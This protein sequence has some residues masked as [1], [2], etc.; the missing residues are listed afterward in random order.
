MHE[1]NSDP[2]ALVASHQMT[3]SPYQSHQ[4]SYQNSQHQQSVSPYQSLQYG[5]PFESQQYSVN[6]SSTPHLITY[7][8]NN[9]QTSVHHNVYSPPVSIPQ[10]EYSPTVNQQSE[11]SQLDS[12]LT[13]PV[14][15]RGDDLI[16]AI[17]HVM[18]L[19]SAV[20]TSRFPTTNNQL[21]NSSNPRQ[22]A[23]INNGRVTVQP[24]QRRQISYA[25]ST[26]R[27][28]TPAATKQCTQP[29]RPRNAA[30]YKE[31]EM[32]AEAQDA[33]QILDEEQLAFLADPG[34]LDTYDSDCDDLATAQAVLMANISS[35]GSDVIY[36]V[37]NP[38][39][40][41]NDIEDQS[42][43]AM[44]DFEQSP[45]M[46]LS[47]NEIHIEQAKGKQPLDT[48]LDFACKYA[49]R[50]QEFLIYVHDTCP[51]AI[52]PSAK[53]V[54]VTPLNK[55][56]KVRFAEPLT[57]SNNTKQVES[58]KTSDSN[59]PVLS[60]TGVK[61]STSNC[62][63]T[64]PGNKKN[65]RISQ[66][67]SR[68]M[69]NKVEAQPRKVNK[70]NRVAE[71]ICDADI[72]HSC[73]TNSAVLCVTCNKSMFDGVHDKCLLDF[74]KN[75]NNRAKSAKKHK[76]KNVWKPTGHVFTDVGYKWK[77]TGRT[78]TIV[79]NLCPLTRITSTN[80]VQIVLWYLDSGCSK[81]ITGNRSQLIYFVSKFLGTVRF[82]NDQIAR[83]M[84]DTNLYTISLDD[85]LQ[86]TSICLLSKASKSKSWLWHRQL[87]HLNFG[88]LNKL[89]KDGLARG[90][91]RLKF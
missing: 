55:V 61:C 74:V 34:D 42:V 28:F 57:S 9:Y 81:H 18:S 83:I 85:M 24:I 63:S 13:I 77:P 29:K 23:T 50:I 25:A 70:K 1:R 7:P 36:E 31:K 4:H 80:V 33:G 62:R 48:E 37:P 91:P 27:T 66:N 87:S 67:P 26:T 88:D 41:L 35:Y 89:D 40:Y 47:D 90:L 69:K 16:D 32:L 54:A 2:L 44:Q 11:F 15:K 51:N 21:R 20:V 3:Q 53:E 64:P 39:Q 38:E 6:Q 72:K 46:D 76:T 14:F 58:S 73:N 30:W 10:S 52:K 82:G 8:L 45:N 19:L 68:N 22:Q 75:G 60:S 79:G 71:P 86:Y 17:N 12:G 59:T 65:D 56:K 49:T 43:H 5:S 84:R 78:F